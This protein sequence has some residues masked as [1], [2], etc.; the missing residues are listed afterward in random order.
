[1]V[2]LD[3]SA[4][5]ICAKVRMDEEIISIRDCQY[6]DYII[7]P[8]FYGKIKRSIQSSFPAIQIALL[9]GC[10]RVY[11]VGFDLYSSGWIYATSE[12]VRHTPKKTEEY[13]KY[14]DHFAR[15]IGDENRAKVTAISGP[16]TQIFGGLK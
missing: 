1:M 15:W 8:S 14:Y 12:M 9:M 3:E 5:E 13:L 11:L 6:T 10:N 16:L 2:C 4:P 7:D